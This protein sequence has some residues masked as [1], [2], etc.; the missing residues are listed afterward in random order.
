MPR[1]ASWKWW[2]G[3]IVSALA[4]TDFFRWIGDHL[5][6]RFD[7]LGTVLVSVAQSLKP[8]AWPVASA[9]ALYWFLDRRLRQ[10]EATSAGAAARLE[11]TIDDKGIPA[12]EPNWAAPTQVFFM[13]MTGPTLRSS[14]DKKLTAE[15]YIGTHQRLPEGTRVV[16]WTVRFNLGGMLLPAWTFE[17]R[18]IE[19]HA[20]GRTKLFPAPEL[21]AHEFFSEKLRDPHQQISVSCEF[22]ALIRVPGLTHEV[23]FN[24]G[25][26]AQVCRVE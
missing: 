2:A 22:F 15:F 24:E 18:D 1:E 14:K 6:Q 7:L 17:T 9:V 21:S 19:L 23:K 8:G 4:G 20:V 5:K 11:G 16:K 25:S 13:E 26:W 10:A 12:S 3:I